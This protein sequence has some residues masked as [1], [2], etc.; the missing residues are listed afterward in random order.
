MRE[1]SEPAGRSLSPG[2][3]RKTPLPSSVSRSSRRDLQGPRGKGAPERIDKAG[4]KKIGAVTQAPRQVGLAPV[5]CA[6]CLRAKLT[7][8]DDD[9]ARLGSARH[10]MAPRDRAIAGRTCENETVIPVE[11]R[12]KLRSRIR[13]EL[14][15]MMDCPAHSL[16]Q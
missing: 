4:I 3:A 11:D 9:G 14:F 8:L 15:G 13:R 1:G 16:G 10:R 12:Q 2:K 7:R 6:P 5:R